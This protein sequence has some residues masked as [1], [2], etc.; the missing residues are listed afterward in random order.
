MKTTMNCNNSCR[1][2]CSCR[3]VE[4]NCIA[5]VLLAHLHGT[6]IRG[7]ESANPKTN[8]TATN[9]GRQSTV[10][11]IHTV[12]HC[13]VPQTGSRVRTEATTVQLWPSS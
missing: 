5:A 11:P 12:L 1:N 10:L 13:W 2:G 8:R 3:A 4:H 7:S 9:K 6:W